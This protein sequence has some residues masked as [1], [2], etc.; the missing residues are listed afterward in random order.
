MGSLFIQWSS[1]F[2]LGNQQ[3][4]DQHRQLIDILNRLYKAF[5]K[6]QSDTV[7][8]EILNKLNHYADIHFKTEEELFVKWNYKDIKNHQE[9]HQFYKRKI[10]EY[11]NLADQQVSIDFSVLSF[12]K[13][14]WTDHI[15]IEDKKYMGQAGI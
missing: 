14:W 5:L 12:L 10:K 1:E 8:A 7:M 15:L 11:E 4:D 2:E 6:K 13:K 9:E 3:I